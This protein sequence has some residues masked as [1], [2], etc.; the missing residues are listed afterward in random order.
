LQAGVAEEE[1]GGGD[2]CSVAV[3]AELVPV[4]LGADEV[5]HNTEELVE[6]EDVGMAAVLP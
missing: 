5:G 3:V 1:Y 2:C 4:P 6:L